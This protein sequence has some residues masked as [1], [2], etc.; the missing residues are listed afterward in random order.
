MWEY[1]QHPF[2]PGIPLPYQ[3]I[4]DGA[5]WFEAVP[6]ASHQHH[7]PATHQ[8][9]RHPPQLQQ[10]SGPAAEGLVGPPLSNLFVQYHQPPQHIADPQQFGA[11]VEPGSGGGGSATVSTFQHGIQGYG[12]VSRR[13]PKL[14]PIRNNL[15]H[16][17]T[18]LPGIRRILDLPTAHLEIAP[19]Q[20]CQHQE[21]PFSKKETL[22][23]R[24]RSKRT[25]KRRKESFASED[26]LDKADSVCHAAPAVLK[27]PPFWQDMVRPN[28]T[29]HPPPKRQRRLPPALSP[30]LPTGIFG[31]PCRLQGVPPATETPMA[32]SVQSNVWS[33]PQPESQHVTRSEDIDASSQAELI[34]KLASK[35]S[36]LITHRAHEVFSEEHCEKIL[37][38]ALHGVSSPAIGWLLSFELPKPSSSGTAKRQILQASIDKLVR[39]FIAELA[40]GQNRTTGVDEMVEHL[41]QQGDRL[42]WS[43]WILQK[44]VDFMSTAGDKAAREQASRDR[45]D[46]VLYRI[47][48]GGQNPQPADTQAHRALIREPM[49]QKMMREQFGYREGSHDAER[50][51][52]KKW[53]HKIRELGELPDRLTEAEVGTGTSEPEQTEIS[54]DHK[55]TL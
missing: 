38:L 24:G 16:E 32:E 6:L 53:L 31:K 5:G 36:F 30:T 48:H 34:V 19:F 14:P 18:Q 15:R 51:L 23:V 40:M 44:A 12:V 55:M 26:A 7:Q 47:N 42:G 37:W 22:F 41:L 10:Q 20:R 1:H 27:H 49:E 11:L 8:R 3:V 29:V 4:D 35:P 52:M 21:E 46:L 13:G 43:R 33:T 28:D 50:K 25:S 9:I 45:K 54:G 39:C 2:D 17:D